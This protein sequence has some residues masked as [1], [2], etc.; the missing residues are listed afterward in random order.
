M[1]IVDGIRSSTQGAGRW[2]DKHRLIVLL[3]LTTW[4]AIL[5]GVFARAKPFWH[6][7]VYTILAADLP[8]SAMWRAS[9]DG[10]DLSPPLNTLLTRGL[11][12]ITGVGLIATRVP[13]MAGLLAA[14]VL[15][16]LTV[17]RRTNPLVGLVA[18]LIPCFTPAFSYGFEA[19]GYGLTIGLFAAA[20]YA[21]SE[22]T[23]GRRST[24]HLTL[25]A[26]ALTAGVWTHYYAVLAFLP[27][28]VGET[29]RQAAERRIQKAPWVA[30]ASAALGILPLWPLMVVASSQRG[31]F[32]TGVVTPGV[33]D[34]YAF[35]V[36]D[37]TTH[38]LAGIVLIVVIA[39]ETVRRAVTR[40]A[41]RRLAPH[42]LAMCVACL[43]LP[44]A[45]T[46]LG[47]LTSA[48]TERYVVFATVGLA[49]AVPLLLWWL[50]PDS[51]VGDTVAAVSLGWALLAFTAR[52]GV[53]PPTWREPM[54]YH[55]LLASTLKAPG[56]AIAMTGGVAFLGI[57]FNLP[58]HA[59][60]R[61][62]YL[63]DP[64]AQLRMNG[65]DTIDRGYLALARWTTVPVA[66][67]A[68]F[69]R[70]SDKFL[71]YSFGSGWVEQTLHSMGAVMVEHARDPTG[72]AVLYDVSVAKP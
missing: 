60:Q 35:V 51:G 28:V 30:L 61:V 66:R 46:V 50:T 62:I 58:G 45:G 41:S 20:I 52:T 13:A 57:W 36:G 21:W 54:D 10:L 11:H 31:T 9:L 19:R 22:A 16:F 49:F 3:V 24:F 39:A 47:V 33:G 7:E 14:V 40:R 44:A 56:G 68:D 53:A 37:L 5:L 6:D 27:V 18:A 55:P 59:R 64:A 34:T 69:T 4:I 25:M 15:L 65:T 43:A 72:L 67:A 42:D 12:T 23:A 63:A 26:I 38:R 71:L 2:L 8:V 32:W 17:R 70:T 29:V 1:V 48:F